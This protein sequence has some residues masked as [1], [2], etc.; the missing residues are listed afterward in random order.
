VPPNG[1]TEA[2]GH[3]EAGARKVVISAPGKD[4]DATI[5][6]GLNEPVYDPARH[7]IISNGSCTANPDRNGPPA[8]VRAGA[9]ALA[10]DE[11]GRTPA[12]E[13]RRTR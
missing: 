7:D 5:V 6:M 1:A 9:A 4:V 8:L 13:V 10:G 12:R 3:L 11:R 2:G